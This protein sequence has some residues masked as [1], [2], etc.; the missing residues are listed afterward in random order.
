MELNLEIVLVK[1]EVFNQLAIFSA[2]DLEK[3]DVQIESRGLFLL[4]LF[5]TEL[6][7]SQVWCLLYFLTAALGLKNI[8]IK[9]S[10]FLTGLSAWDERDQTKR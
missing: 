4:F 10:A 1:L 3:H 6:L 9:E 5:P 2:G 7:S 8:H